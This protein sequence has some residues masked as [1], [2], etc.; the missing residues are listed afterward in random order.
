MRCASIRTGQVLVL[1][2]L[3][4]HVFPCRALAQSNS[5]FAGEVRDTS[6]GLLP[7]VTVEA[8][9]PALI[10]KVRSTVTDAQGLYRIIDLRPGV[11]T[12]SFTL[13]GFNTF[14]RADVELTASFTATVNA[15]MRV[16]SVQETV[17]V[18]GAVPTV[19][20]QNVVQ[21]RVLTRDV[22]DAIPV[23]TK[24]VMAMTVL[25]PGVT[26]NSQDVGGTQYGSAAVAI[27][28][29]RLQEAALLYDGMYYNNGGGRGG[30]FTAIAIND[31]TVQEVSIETGGLSAENELGGIRSNIIP[32]EGG[33]SF[34]GSMFAA[35]TNDALQGS[36]LSD[37]LRAGGL[38]SVDR[39]N[40]IYDLN[41]A[42]G[43]PLKKDKLW[44]FG[45]YRQWETNQ[46]A[47]GLFY[48]K[49]TLPWI[50]EPDLSRPAFEGD[51][52]KNVSIRLTWQ[53]AAKHK[54][55]FQHQQADQLR[56][57]FYSMSTT[58]RT[59]A[60]E[61]TIH[62]HGQPSF[63]TQAG[64]SA[65]LTR[66]V[67]LE[68]GVAYAAKDF[69][70]EMQEDEGITDASVPWRDLG[71][72]LSWGN[73]S[74]LPY[75]HNDT[76]QYNWRVAA[77]Y[78]TG[79]HAAKVGLSFQH[80]WVWTTQNVPNNGMIQELRNG[81]PSRVTVWATPLEFDEVT[82]AN[83]GL[84]AQ[85]QWRLDRLTL[86]LGVR[87]DYL[88]SYVPEQT[89]GP[90]PQVPNRQVTFPQVNDVPNWTDIS[91]RAGFALD[92]FGNGRTA[93]KANIGRYLE[94]PNL[95]TFTRRANP[96]NAIVT[97]AT[98]TW[99]DSNG[100]FIPQPNELD[101]LSSSSFG[102]SN[103]TTR[104]DDEVLKNRGYN[105]EISTSIQHELASRVSVNAGYFRRWYGN[106]IATDN[107]RVTP[108][109]YSPYCVTA[110]P[111]SR[112]PGGGAYQVCGLA[113]VNPSRFGQ[114]DNLI[115][116]SENFGKQKEIYNGV[117]LGLNLRFPGGAVLQGGTS[118]G[119][120]STDNCFVV[121]SPQ[122]LLNCKV[123]Q[124]FKTQVKVLGV[125]PLPVWGLQAAA[126]FQS[127][128]GPEITASYA[129]PN[130]AIAPSLG[131]NL[132]AGATAT[133]TVPLVSPGTLYGD[134]LNQIDFRATRSFALGA[135]RRLQAN[136][137]VYN[138]A[139]ASPVLTLNNTFG[140]AWQR[141]LQILHARMLK[142]SAQVE[143]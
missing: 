88:N 35:F 124:P 126:T 87:F 76:H 139:N 108:A 18:T 55:T 136:V 98:R 89:E 100:D 17:A 46:Y 102:S 31:A 105:W 29:S 133:A 97:N 62:F 99:N 134:R 36:N 123:T 61:A 129:A 72:G 6:G 19:D 128:P 117:D 40:Y 68:G 74:V 78:V 15:E 53:A 95:T 14:Q 103:V 127:L 21:Q 59:Q 2:L 137:D 92:L 33:N 65:P 75:G 8:S 66:R 69:Q 132:S 4:V 112:L 107:L 122:Q 101:A 111:D 47:A 23:G 79:A 125:Y 67:L 90:G 143:F 54:V 3:A 135:G 37:K 130:S 142:F 83:V 84:F 63:F 1:A 34:T 48:N 110:P 58:N 7:G 45:A 44:F 16:G 115:S 13:P 106:F 20:V 113:D 85:D 131:R 81:V 56:D 141:P 80:A 38:Q 41:P 10:E 22:I 42:I 32:R 121:D 5:G 104:Y 138:L 71:T 96:A 9:S 30:S 50:F 86:N 57:H 77:S 114:V 51:A 24:S 12:V 49:S 94:G 116:M 109:D 93:V 140:P 70:Y 118:T 52:D 39:V 73:I 28:G 119:R 26:T 11:Y 91:P 120:L 60:P 27:H 43:G 82:K 64:W 25:I